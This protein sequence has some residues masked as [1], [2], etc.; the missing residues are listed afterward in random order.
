MTIHL[1]RTLRYGSSDTT[2]EL[3][4]AAHPLFGL[5]PGGVCQATTVSSPP[6][7]SYRT[8]SPLPDSEGPWGQRP[9]R[10]SALCG[11][12][13]RVAPSWCYQAP[14]PYGARTFLPSRRSKD[15]RYRRSPRPPRRGRAGNVG[16]RRPVFKEKRYSLRSGP[17]Q[18]SAMTSAAESSEAG[19]GSVSGSSHDSR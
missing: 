4:R 19:G 9:V 5:A 15:R 7:R 10:R 3:G 16:G 2:R 18:A 13:Q 8:L 6:V 14:L 17:D 11:T 12:F 1:A